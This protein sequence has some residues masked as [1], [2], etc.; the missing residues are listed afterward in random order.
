M[1]DAELKGSDKLPVK[2]FQEMEGQ[3]PKQRAVGD[4]KC[5]PMLILSFFIIVLIVPSLVS[6]VVGAEETTH[7]ILIS[8]S[9]RQLS[10]ISAKGVILKTYSIASGRGGP[11]DK[12]RLG[13]QKTPT[14]RYKVAGFKS[15]SDFFYFVRLNYP[16]ENDARRGFRDKLINKRQYNAI[17][18]ALDNNMTPPQGTKLGGAI[19][20]HGIGEE[21]Q[22]KISMHNTLDWTQ[23][24]IAL[25]NHEV[26]DLLAFLSVGIHVVIKD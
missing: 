10:V 1:S 2:I 25:R 23:G 15:N 12:Y 13:D 19:G 20:I 5:Y 21:S 11:G 14:G 18:E 6:D 24:C 7:Y 16:N 8:K 9:N 22:S 3:T 4:N 17:L 26:E